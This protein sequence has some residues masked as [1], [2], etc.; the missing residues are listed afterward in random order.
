MFEIWFSSIPYRLHRRHWPLVGTRPLVGAV[1]SG[2]VDG[3]LASLPSRL[4]PLMEA[5]A[6]LSRCAVWKWEK[7]QAVPRHQAAQKNS[8]ILNPAPPLLEA[9]PCWL[10]CGMA[11]IYVRERQCE[12]KSK[13][14]P[15]CPHPPW[16]WWS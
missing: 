14:C 9:C 8:K 1:G 4:R 6:P 15:P 2:T 13:L 5:A 3:G 16:R 12:K 10:G 7:H 11:K